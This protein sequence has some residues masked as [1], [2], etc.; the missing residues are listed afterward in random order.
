LARA[1][2]VQLFLRDGVLKPNDDLDG[3]VA[4]AAEATGL[5]SNFSQRYRSP[6]LSKTP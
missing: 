5:R 1:A 4:I 3:A 2:S 6:E